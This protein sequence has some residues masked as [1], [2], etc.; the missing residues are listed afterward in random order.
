[1]K[2]LPLPDTTKLEWGNLS[3][4]S[5]RFYGSPNHD[6][7]IAAASNIADPNKIQVAQQVTLPVLS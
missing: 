1:M 7:H 3:K 5:E 4:I 2:L 6:S